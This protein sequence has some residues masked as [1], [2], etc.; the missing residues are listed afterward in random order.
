VGLVSVMAQCGALVPA[1]AAELGVCDRILTRIESVESLTALHEVTMDAQQV[2]S[3]LLHATPRSLLL[4]DELG[5]G[6]TA[7]DAAALLSSAAVTHAL[8]SRRAPA[9]RRAAPRTIITTHLIE[10]LD[11]KLLQHCIMDKH[12][13]QLPEARRNMMLC[14]IKVLLLDDDNDDEAGDGDGDGKY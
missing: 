8:P 5:K 10:I 11:T 3:M 6:T 1:A 7:L 2:A 13:S 4:V 9:A 12:A 14:E